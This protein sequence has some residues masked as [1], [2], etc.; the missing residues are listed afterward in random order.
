MNLPYITTVGIYAFLFL[1]HLTFF[2]IH[3]LCVTSILL[4]VKVSFGL[5]AISSAVVFG[6]GLVSNGNIFETPSPSAISIMTNANVIGS[7]SSSSSS[8]TLDGVTLLQ[9]QL[10]DEA[11]ASSILA[12]S[13]AVATFE[14]KKLVDTDV[15]VATKPFEKSSS[16]STFAD[17]KSVKEISLVDF[18]TQKQPRDTDAEKVEET[19]A[20]FEENTAEN[21]GPSIATIAP[22]REAETDEV[23]VEEETARNTE[24]KEPEKQTRTTSTLVEFLTRIPESEKVNR[25]RNLED[26]SYPPATII[27]TPNEEIA[28]TSDDVVS[29]NGKTDSS[30][31]L[32]PF[33]TENQV[34]GTDLATTSNENSVEL[35]PLTVTVGV[36]GV[37]A[38]GI[39]SEIV[40]ADDDDIGG[41]AMTNQVTMAKNNKSSNVERK[42]RAYPLVETFYEPGTLTP[43]QLAA[44]QK[45][46]ALT[47]ETSGN[48]SVPK[49]A[50]IAQSVEP[51]SPDE[52]RDAV[53]ALK[54]PEKDIVH[55]KDLAYKE[56]S[57]DGE[58]KLSDSTKAAQ[59]LPKPN[60]TSGSYLDQLSWASTTMIGA[61]GTG[62]LTTKKG[63]SQG[64]YLDNLSKPTAY[65]VRE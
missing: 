27:V 9:A 37:V 31:L 23:K 34:V 29:S 56:S 15:I 8:N 22:N 53:D 17:G 14:D 35:L 51:K 50:S 62:E 41:Q 24:M 48:V 65:S 54:T 1:P 21:E 16:S 13:E 39:L 47:Q 30:Q 57:R 52:I 55:K 2:D 26:I 28:V 10:V 3:S 33:E 18:L 42:A 12:I 63:P 61:S 43:E 44:L 58:K 7:S 49:K 59:Q 45:P 25:M 40:A 20:R 38:F 6:G 64:S 36:V 4:P 32:L 19:V 5:S 11:M 60:M 46:T